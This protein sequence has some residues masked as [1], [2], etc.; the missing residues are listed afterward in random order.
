MRKD[1]HPARRDKDP[2]LEEVLRDLVF[3]NK[4]LNE[5]GVPTTFFL[6]HVGVNS[7]PTDV[8]AIDED[9]DAYVEGEERRMIVWIDESE[10]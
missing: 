8:L 1:S 2:E 10:K 3:I 4:F 5:R 6:H 7:I 9:G